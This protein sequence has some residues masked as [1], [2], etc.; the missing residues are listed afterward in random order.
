[1]TFALAEDAAI[2]TYLSGMTVS[3]EKSASRPVGVWF[4]Y[5]DVELRQQIFPFVT[6]LDFKSGL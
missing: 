6:I 2:K 5:P 3:D 4:G 1:M